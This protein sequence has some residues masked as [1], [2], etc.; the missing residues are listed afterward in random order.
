[1][2]LINIEVLLANRSRRSTITMNEGTCSD[3]SRN[4]FRLGFLADLCM[5]ALSI[6]QLL[7]ASY[8]AFYKGGSMSI[9]L[10]EEGLLLSSRCRMQIKTQSAK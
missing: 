2:W 7:Y 4:M 6:W 5:H 10:E 1:V 8:T 9:E 3:E